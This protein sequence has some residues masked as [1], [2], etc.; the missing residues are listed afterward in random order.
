MKLC[1]KWNRITAKMLKFNKMRLNLKLQKFM[2]KYLNNRQLFIYGKFRS[3]ARRYLLLSFNKRR[4]TALG[5]WNSLAKKYLKFRSL[6]LSSKWFKMADR[7]L[8]LYDEQHKKKR[9]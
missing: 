4:L 1:G 8:C 7:M 9:V 3:M 5:K 6:Q 2:Q